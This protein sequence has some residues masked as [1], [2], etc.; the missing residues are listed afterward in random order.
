MIEEKHYSDEFVNTIIPIVAAANA[1]NGHHSIVLIVRDEA[2]R[3]NGLGYTATSARLYD[4]AKKLDA[5]FAE[6]ERIKAHDDETITICVPLSTCKEA[7]RLL[8]GAF[9]DLSNS[10]D[11]PV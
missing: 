11:I 10:E 6:I 3:L 1:L 7:R 9:R 5:L 8:G 2:R 4:A